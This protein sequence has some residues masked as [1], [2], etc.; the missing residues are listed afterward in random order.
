[1][2]GAVVFDIGKVLYEWDLR[3]LLSQFYGGEELDF[4]HRNVVSEA[5]HFQVDQGRDLADMVAERTAEFPQYADAINAYMHRF[6]ETIPGPVAGS[7]KIVRALFARGIPLFAITNFGH[8]FW[9]GFRSNQP[10]FDLFTDIVVSGTEKMFKPNPDI[11]ALAAQRFGHPSAN[12]LFIDDNAGNIAAARALGWQVH[13]FTDAA[14][15]ETDMQT[16]GLI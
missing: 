15:L 8:E 5:W 10:I 12:M 11:F 3:L 2:I 6:N 4:V 13:H 7:H 1:M 14:G 9:Q 16:R